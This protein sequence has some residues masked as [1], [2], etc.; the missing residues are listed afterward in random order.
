[1]S[2]KVTPKRRR[3]RTSA[4][5][6]RPP[7]S[8]VML[9]LLLTGLLVSQV[10]IAALPSRNVAD[11]IPQSA[12]RNDPLPYGPDTCQVGYVWREARPTDH[13]CVTPETR[14]VTR[15][16]NS[17]AGSRREPAGG[18]Y[19]P[20]TCKQGFVW[21]EAF[22]GDVVCVSPD[23]RAQAR[24][25]NNAAAGRRAGS[26]DPRSPGDHTV[27]LRVDRAS[28][29][30]TRRT[31]DCYFGGRGNPNGFVVGFAQ[32]ELDGGAPC[33]ADI[34]E[35]ALH[36]DEGPLNQIPDKLI[37][38]AVLTYDEAP[39]D[40]CFVFYNSI[41]GAWIGI[42]P[43]STPGSTSTCWR[44]GSGVQQPKP[45]GCVT[46]L[47]VP[48]VD[49]ANSARGGLLPHQTYPRQV[50]RVSPR[51]WDVSTIYSWQYERTAALGGSPPP[52]F[53]FLLRGP[54]TSFSNLTGE[55]RTACASVLSNIRLTVTYKVL[56]AGPPVVVR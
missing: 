34:V 21:R 14:Q 42:S 33:G 24:A 16:E 36:F 30:E 13:V 7:L 9:G 23:R 2:L 49:W 6:R 8:L 43:I 5:C 38:R 56:P 46:N 50:Q 31:Y 4:I 10:S 22:D 47:G 26:G 40:G 20:N 39:A 15:D 19:G 41:G 55:D 52:P 44:S 53:G 32:Y 37:T 17:L 18:P 28:G 3:E 54:V 29:Q 51:E 27:V 25:D 1:M 11:V 48:T 12:L 35:T 45:N